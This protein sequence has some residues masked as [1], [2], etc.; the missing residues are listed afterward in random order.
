MSEI[1]LEQLEEA[2]HI[3]AE[4]LQTIE[5]QL[6]I[7]PKPLTGK[8]VIYKNRICKK[9]TLEPI[10]EEEPV[11][12]LRGRD[13]FAI[14]LLRFFDS[15]CREDGATEWQLNVNKETLGAFERFAREHPERMK[16]P[17]ITMGK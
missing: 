9:D 13:K 8:F 12:I 2:K 17:G 5:E 16:Q 14:R 7:L 11:F 4:R 1:T 6:G 15:L 3:I 10:P